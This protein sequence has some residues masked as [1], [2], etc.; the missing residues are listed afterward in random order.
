MRR[1]RHAVLAIVVVAAAAF[2]VSDDA[3]ADAFTPGIHGFLDTGGTFT[4]IDVPGAANTLAKGPGG[5]G[6]LHGND[7]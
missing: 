2:V 1:D 3:D 5:G 6:G 4:Q 7:F